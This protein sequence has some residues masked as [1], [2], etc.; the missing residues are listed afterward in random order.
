MLTLCWGPKAARQSIESDVRRNMDVLMKGGGFVFSA[1][2]SIQ[3]E[4][5]PETTLRVYD[6]A[7]APRRYR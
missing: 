7:V 6:T 3:H 2:H 4:V 1:T 5:A